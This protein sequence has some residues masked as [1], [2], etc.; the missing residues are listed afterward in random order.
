MHPLCKHLNN[1]QKSDECECALMKKEEIVQ[2][3]RGN[4]NVIRVVL[5]FWHWASAK[6]MKE[7]D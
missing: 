6:K 1:R 2:N 7:D 3:Q 4:P 5:A